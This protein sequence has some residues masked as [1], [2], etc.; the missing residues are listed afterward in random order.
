MMELRHLSSLEELSAAEWDRLAG[1]DRDPFLSHAFLA[2]LERHGCVGAHWGWTPRHLAVREGGR[3]VGAMPLYLKHN[4]YGELVFD[5]A[6]ADALQRA[7]GRYYPK[8]V[9]AVPYSPVTGPRLLV[10]P[11]AARPDAVAAALAEGAL[12][13]ARSLGVSSLHILFPDEGQGRLLTGPGQSF[14]AR[15]DCQFHWHNRGYRDFEDFL[16]GFNAQ[17]R[18][19]VRRERRRVAE[20]GVELRVL[21]GGEVSEGQW[22][23]FHQFYASTFDKRGGHPTLTLEFFRELGRRLGD[24]VV[25][26]LAC[27]QGREVAGAFCLRSADTLYGRHWGCLEAFHSLHFEACYY[28]GI[29]YCI[30]Q[31][32]R[33]FEP[34]AQGEHKVWRGFEPTLTWSAHWLADSGFHRL[35]GNHLARERAGVF[36]YLEEM[37]SHLP[38]R[39]D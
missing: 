29:D 13:L 36:D 34:G 25:L 1:P 4:S 14:L 28:Q 16:E 26:I 33:R 9:S 15:H 39:K 2:G 37:R 5:W 17:R 12:G 35:V 8:L 30:R 38:F 19:Q 3:L 20:A 23:L 18:K 22:A 24:R 11:D 27:H 32:L 31:G 7:G 10:A 6:W 21:H